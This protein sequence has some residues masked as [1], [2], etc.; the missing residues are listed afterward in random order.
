MANS[1]LWIFKKIEDSQTVTVQGDES[2][3]HL[4]NVLK[5]LEPG[6]WGIKSFEAVRFQ[7]IE[8]WIFERSEDSRAD[9]RMPEQVLDVPRGTMTKLPPPPLPPPAPMAKAKEAPRSRFA[10]EGISLKFSR[11][12]PES[13]K[14]KKDNRRHTRV[15]G[16]L[17]I[18]LIS[19]NRSFRTYSKNLSKGGLL[20]ENKIPKEFLGEAC[21]VI[22]GSPDLKE[23]LEFQARVLVKGEQASSLEFTESKDMFMKKFET[24]MDLL[25]VARAV[26][27]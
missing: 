19:G 18:M 4:A 13:P 7:L 27:A 21:R 6:R 17:R 1:N 26:A 23:N 15:N 20:L 11:E 16:R 5:G 24:W 14:A 22:I 3:S 10:G 12:I 2:A 9:T 25:K 8:N